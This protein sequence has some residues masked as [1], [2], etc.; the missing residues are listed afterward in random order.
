MIKYS[1]TYRQNHQEEINKF[2]ELVKQKFKGVENDIYNKGLK[3]I[4]WLLKNYPYNDYNKNENFE[5]N[6]NK[7]PIKYFENLAFKYLPDK[8]PIDTEEKR[9]YY[10]KIQII[11]QNLNDLNDKLENINSNNIN[12]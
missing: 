5:I 8:Y 4:E 9:E 11:S 7:Y 2:E 6:F 1:A 3:L 10:I 12:E